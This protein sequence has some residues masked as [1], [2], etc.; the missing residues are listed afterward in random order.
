[1]TIQ[2]VRRLRI[3]GFFVSA[4][5][6]F[7]VGLCGQNVWGT[8]P[9]VPQLPPREL[10]ISGICLSIGFLNYTLSASKNCVRKAKQAL[11]LAEWTTLVS[12]EKRTRVNS[13][14]PKC[15]V[16]AVLAKTE[17]RAYPTFFEC[18]RHGRLQGNRTY[19]LHFCSVRGIPQTCQVRITVGIDQELAV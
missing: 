14:L 13:Q 3:V 16:A 4:P 11:H 19:D 5:V 7:C 10:H 9:H 2:P 1:M 6:G 15:Q 18:V 17:W 8:Q 12:Y